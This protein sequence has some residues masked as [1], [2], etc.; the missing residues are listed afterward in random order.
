MGR[1]DVGALEARLIGRAYDRAELTS[2]LA[3]VTVSDYVG[4]VSRED[5][6]DLICP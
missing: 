1:E 6:L 3:G 4:D 2:A 5:L